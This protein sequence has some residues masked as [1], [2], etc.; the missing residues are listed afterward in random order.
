MNDKNLEQAREIWNMQKGK[1]YRYKTTDY[2]LLEKGEG[3]CS[4]FIQASG[5]LEKDPIDWIRNFD[6]RLSKQYMGGRSIIVHN[7]IWNAFQELLIDITPKIQGMKEV[8]LSG[9]SH[10]GAIAILFNSYLKT[11]TN[12]KV[13]SCYTFG[14]PRVYN[15]LGLRGF[16]DMRELNK[17]IK[18]FRINRDIVPTLPFWWMGYKQVGEVIR[19][20]TNSNKPKNFIDWLKQPFIDHGSYP[21]ELKG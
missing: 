9:T 7:G 14:A 12:I 8:E 6:A 2:N 1:R 15:V 11:Y 5:S 10:G 16:L 13:K 17:N 4:I 3:K 20:K 21:K 19:L 18:H